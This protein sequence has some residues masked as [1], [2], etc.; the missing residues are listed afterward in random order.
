M[1][2]LII[3]LAA[4][5]NATLAEAQTP[6]T[7]SRWA[8]PDGLFSL[9]VN[10]FVNRGPE[11]RYVIALLVP[12]ETPAGAPPQTMCRV[13]HRPFWTDGTQAD[14]VMNGLLRRRLPASASVTESSVDGVTVFNFAEDHGSFAIHYRVFQLP[15]ARG[16]DYHELTCGGSTPISVE[17]W[18]SLD[19]LLN[20]L[21]FRRR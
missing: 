15:S 8:H 17:Q 21:V 11:D 12:T 14:D 16:N 13:T 2:F 9:D 6:E 18:A 1:R 19:A 10:G 7:A 4:L 20:S 5:L 3:I